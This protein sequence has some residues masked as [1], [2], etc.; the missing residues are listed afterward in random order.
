MEWM[1][2]SS[3][4]REFLRRSYEGRQAFWSHFLINRYVVLVFRFVLAGTFLLSSI[5]KLVDIRHYSVLMVYHYGILPVPLA[6]AFGWSL[7]FIELAC[8]LGLLF[9]VLT[10]LS[11]LGIAVLSAS[12][13]AVKTMLLMQGV[14]IECG[15][16][17][18]IVSTMASVSIYLDPAICLMSLTVLLSPGPSRHWVSFGKKLPQKWSAK[19]TLIW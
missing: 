11:A 17:G 18:A 9:G 19:L 1:R 10:R 12:F 3:Q 14:D 6:I 5:G 2:W 8:A 15:C 4:R 16:F 7:P 13:L